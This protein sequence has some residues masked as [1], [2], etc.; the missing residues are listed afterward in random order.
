MAI[1]ETDVRLYASERMTD[2]AD[3]GGAMSPTVIVDGLDNNVFPDVSDIDR[4]TGRSSVRKVFGAV[5]SADTDTYLSAHAMLD[6]AADDGAID[7]ML[8]SFGD[9][10]T[11]RAVLATAMTALQGLSAIFQGTLGGTSSTVTTTAA[12]TTTAGS[13][14]VTLRIFG[15]SPPSNHILPGALVTVVP[16]GGFYGVGYLRSVVSVTDGPVVG[17]QIEATVVLDAAI[18]VSATGGNFWLIGFSHARP[19]GVSISS[20]GAASGASS[21]TVGSVFARVIPV[22]NSAAFPVNASNAQWLVS[23][24]AYLYTQ[25]RTQIIRPND[26]LLI[27]STLGMAPATVANAQTVTTG[28]TSLARLRVIGNNG[29]EHARFTRGVPAPT[30]V[31]CTADLTAGT[32]TFSNVSGMSQPVTVE[33]RIEEM[34]LASAVSVGTGAITLNRALSRAFPAGTKVSS[35]C[36]LGD[37]QGRVIGGFAQTA[38]TGV[39]SDTLLGSAPTADFNGAVYPIVTTNA[40]AIADRWLITF[41]NTTT[42]RCTGE[43][44]GEISGGSTGAAYAPIN[45][46]TGA[47]YF[48]IPALGWGSGWSASNV[49][50]FNTSG[51]NAPLWVLRTVA[52]SAPS[53][54]SDSVTVEFRGY[55]NT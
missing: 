43:L 37:L 4:L 7:A 22:D 34:A 30:G 32:V 10:A 14:T 1:T 47:P 49:Y 16:V 19:Y 42:F 35:L 2:F 44:T 3:G 12:V 39:F 8:V 38:W 25:G 40:G 28:R 48:T 41:T 9:N 46:A 17:L 50:R 18:P 29:V 31:G 24:N 23:A 55:V 5:V 52:P 36:M 45:P 53:S 6:D 51:A 20:A 27:H 26:P 33:H 11:E 21:I 15:N 13:A 54:A